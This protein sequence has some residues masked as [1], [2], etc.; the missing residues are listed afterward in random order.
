VTSWLFPK[1]AEEHAPAHPIPSGSAVAPI[2]PTPEVAEVEA[3]EP[4]DADADAPKP[5]RRAGGQDET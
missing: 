3:R 1:A 4:L 2:E 5:A